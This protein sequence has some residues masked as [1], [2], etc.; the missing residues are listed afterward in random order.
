LIAQ[1]AFYVVLAA[2]PI[3]IGVYTLAQPGADGKLPGLSNVINSYNYYKERWAAR[4]TAHTA[5]MEQ[6]AFDKH[7]FQSTKGSTHVPLK[8]P[9]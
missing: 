6:A 3:S 5:M 1:A 9:E 8:F 4:N 2:L 7:L